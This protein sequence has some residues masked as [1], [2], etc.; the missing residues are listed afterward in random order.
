MFL[1]RYKH[2][3]FEG[4]HSAFT[5]KSKAGNLHSMRVNFFYAQPVFNARTYG[6]IVCKSVN[7]FVARC[8]ANG[9]VYTQYGIKRKDAHLG[10]FFANPV[11]CRLDI[12][13]LATLPARPLNLDGSGEH[14]TKITTRLKK[15]KNIFH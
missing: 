5:H 10:R 2:L 3:H 4:W 1:N 6:Y 13:F 9:T 11:D 15:A 12:P 7:F 14:A 8:A